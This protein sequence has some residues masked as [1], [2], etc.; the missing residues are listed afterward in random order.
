INVG[1][2]MANS[3]VNGPGSRFVLWTQGCPIQC[4]G[5]INPQFWADSP[6]KLMTVQDVYMKVISVSEIE[7]ITFTGGEPLEQAE[8]LLTLSYMVKERGLS[9]MVYSGY[10]YE[11]IISSYDEYKFE[12]LNLA[13]I[14][15]DGPYRKGLAA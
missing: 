7:G 14:P 13:D 10:R 2:W 15:V 3:T 11:N 9:I 6:N 1:A 8:S 12:L 5:C 4:D